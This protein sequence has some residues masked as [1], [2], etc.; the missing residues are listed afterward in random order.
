M[1]Q[2]DGYADGAD[3]WRTSASG[4]FGQFMWGQYVARHLH[5]LPLPVGARSLKDVV[6]PDIDFSDVQVVVSGSI[7][8][9][10]VG[11]HSAEVQV[12]VC[13]RV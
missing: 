9:N 7:D 4:D 1:L 12:L 8:H 3:L 6:A 5:I 13:C 10:R 2:S 11:H